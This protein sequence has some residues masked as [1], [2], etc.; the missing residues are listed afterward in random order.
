MKTKSQKEQ[1]KEQ[2][3][4]QPQEQ[5]K[6]KLAG[7]ALA[8]VLPITEAKSLS[9]QDKK[10]IVLFNERCDS[11]KMMLVQ[12]NGSLILLLNEA[13]IFELREMVGK[14]SNDSEIPKNVLAKIEGLKSYAIKA[15]KRLYVDY[16]KERKVKGRSAKV[17][18]RGQYFYAKNESGNEVFDKKNQQLPTQYV[19]KIICA[20]SESLLQKLPPNSIDL[21]F[22]SPPYNFG[23][24]Y[25]Q[26]EDD[27]AWQKYFEKLFAIFDQCIRVLKYGGR[28]IVNVQPLFSDYIPIHHMISQ[29]FIAKKMIWRGEILWEKNNYNCKYTA[30]GS[31][32]SPSNPYLKYTWEFLEIFCKGS[33]KKES[34][35]GENREN[36]DISADEF[37]KW[38]YAKWS[39]APEREMAKYGHPAMFPQELAQRVLKLFSYQGDIVL[40]PFNGLGTTCLVAKKLQRNY[41]GIDFSKD[42]CLAAEKR[43]AEFE[44][45]QIEQSQLEPSQIEKSPKGLSLAG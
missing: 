40:D 41:I 42:Y 24:D 29:H 7:K 28:I 44:P 15:G 14:I 25:Q 23:L 31:W 26:G 21:V 32:K 8:K 35:K 18:K 33:L 43:L 37:K 9:P 11:K 1:P 34:A 6:E 45:N 5:P 20:D 19:D 27:K 22:T 3:Q 36:S 17:E 10:A 30:W 4:E 12:S 2:P 13:D 38:V 39:I 16:N